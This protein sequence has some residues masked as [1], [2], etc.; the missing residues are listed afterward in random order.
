MVGYH[1]ISDRIERQSRSIERCQPVTDALS[2]HLSR[3]NAIHTTGPVILKI[4]STLSIQIFFIL[5]Y[6]ISTHT[7]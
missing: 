3:D 7:G 1:A 5:F 6:C 4:V 2:Y